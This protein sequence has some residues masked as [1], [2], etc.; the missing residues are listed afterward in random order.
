MKLDNIKLSISN[1]KLTDSEKSILL[2]AYKELFTNMYGYD[3]I[4]DYLSSSS[5]LKND[6][7]DIREDTRLI[8]I[9]NE[10]DNLIGGGRIKEIDN[11]TIKVLDIAINHSSENE[12]RNLW[13]MVI[14]YIE[15]YYTDLKYKKMYIE[16]PL[17]EPCLL[18]RADD[19]GFIESP[20]DISI[21]GNNKTY[22]LNKMLESK[23]NE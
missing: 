3:I 13:K 9:Y 19:L 5:S 11:K 14:S 10:D 21:L 6:Y 12:K 2:K 16:I 7:L 8:L 23:D 4:Q 22:V 1:K 20:E 17:N 15:K 18:I